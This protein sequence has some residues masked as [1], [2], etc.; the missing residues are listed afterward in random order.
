[1]GRA[2]WQFC[3]SALVTVGVVSF[4]VLPCPHAVGDKNARKQKNNI[5]LYK[6]KSSSKAKPRIRKKS[7]HIHFTQDRFTLLR[8][9]NS[10]SRFEYCS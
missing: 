1:M 10:Y 4:S 6:I 5:I 7:C 2:E 3:Y 9:H 8:L